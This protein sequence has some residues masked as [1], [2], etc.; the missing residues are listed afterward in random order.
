MNADFWM[1][2]Y[3]LDYDPWVQDSARLGQCSGKR[4][5]ETFGG[6]FRRLDRTRLSSIISLIVGHLLY[7]S[8]YSEMDH[9]GSCR[10]IV[11]D[12]KV[13]NVNSSSLDR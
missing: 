7:Q 5:F 2:R 1:L 8:E 13:I 12:L 6:V 3:V 9:G 4:E 10:S 11:T